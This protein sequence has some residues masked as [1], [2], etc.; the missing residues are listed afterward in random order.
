V[1]TKYAN[2]YFPAASFDSEYL[3]VDISADV[4]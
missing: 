3:E 1:K 4:E 2:V